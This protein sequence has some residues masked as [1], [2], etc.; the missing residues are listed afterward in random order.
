MSDDAE[1]VDAVACRLLEPDGRLPD[2]MPDGPAR[3]LMLAYF[4]CGPISNGGFDSFFSGTLPGDPYYRRF[5]AALSAVGL[6]EAA[7]VFGKVLALFGPDGPPA[8]DGYRLTKFRRAD[9]RVKGELLTAFFRATDNMERP[10]AAYIRAHPADFPD[11]SIPPPRDWVAEPAVSP[12]LAPELGSLADLLG[13]LSYRDRVAFAARCGRRV[14][15]LFDRH[16]PD[17]TPRRRAAL[18]TA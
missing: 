14:L 10:L 13:R 15:P 2:A 6:T 17:A 9:A 5:H 4:G 8:D 7:D 1:M 3:S 11:Q 16:W 18:T 12:P